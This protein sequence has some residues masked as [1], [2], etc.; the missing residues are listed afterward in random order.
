[1]MRCCDCEFREDCAEK[2]NALT[3]FGGCSLRDT[4]LE[5]NEVFDE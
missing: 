4:R 1:M 5:R 3:A 2:Q